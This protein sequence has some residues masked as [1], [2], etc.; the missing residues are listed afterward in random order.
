MKTEIPYDESD[1][2]K[3]INLPVR[4]KIHTY[5]THMDDECLDKKIYH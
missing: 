4:S 3:F 1:Y 2:H 5:Y